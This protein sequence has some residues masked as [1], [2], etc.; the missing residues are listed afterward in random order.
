[1][2]EE[3]GAEVVGLEEA[4]VGVEEEVSSGRL[5]RRRFLKGITAEAD[6]IR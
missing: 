3:V 5:Q 6:I 1:M 4:G 2:G